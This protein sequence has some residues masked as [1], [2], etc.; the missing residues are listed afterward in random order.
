MAAVVSA[1]TV[2]AVAARTGRVIQKT[3]FFRVW[4]KGATLAYQPWHYGR[5]FCMTRPVR[6]ARLR[7]V[8][9]ERTAAIAPTARGNSCFLSKQLWSVG[10]VGDTVGRA[11]DS[12]GRVGD[13]VGAA[14]DSCRA[15]SDTIGSKLSLGGDFSPEQR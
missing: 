15:R 10:R 11:G 12:V 3:S 2:S 9:A 14:G 6:A 1:A 7:A 4:L 8:A 5:V 13:S